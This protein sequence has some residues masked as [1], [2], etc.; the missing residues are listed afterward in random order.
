[1]IWGE[2]DNLFPVWHG[3]A[4]ARTLPRARLVMVPEAA[5]WSPLDAPEAVGREI[6]AFLSDR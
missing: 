2:R 5:H 1:V 3:E 6:E 4:I